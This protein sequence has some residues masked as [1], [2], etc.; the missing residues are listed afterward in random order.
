MTGQLNYTTLS[1]MF[2]VSDK[3]IKEYINYFEDVFLLRRI[4]KFHTNPKE[5][6]KSSKKIYALDNGLMK[7]A[8]KNSKNLGSALENWIFRYLTQ[9]NEDIYYLR[10]TKEIDFY[11]A[12]VLYQVSYEIEDEKTK[13]R[14]VEA[15]FSFSHISTKYCLLTFDTVG[16]SDGINI[17][18]ADSFLLQTYI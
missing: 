14:E 13:K 7:V 16:Q 5:R 2:Q 15:F 6:I 11:C 18:P 12:D 17:M 1:E 3:T 9:Q 10:D 8:P 4:D